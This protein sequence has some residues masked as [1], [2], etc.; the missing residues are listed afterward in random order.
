VSGLADWLPFLSRWQARVDP[1]DN[2][3]EHVLL[4]EVGEKV[5]AVPVMELQR[6]V[7]RVGMLMEVLAT[8]TDRGPVVGA[9]QD[10][11]RERD[12]PEAVVQPLVGPDQRGDRSSPSLF[13]P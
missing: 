11:D 4:A 1:A 2:F 5:V 9:V 10:Q 3:G 8:A 6:L 12:L 13:R 7:R